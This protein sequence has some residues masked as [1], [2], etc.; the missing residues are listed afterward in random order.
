MQYCQKPVNV[1]LH[2]RQH[3]ATLAANNSTVKWCS[4][5]DP[6]Q[7]SLPGEV[8]AD[9]WNIQESSVKD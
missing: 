7:C 6:R 4:V 5:S 1:E 9:D 2:L 3:F 8:Y